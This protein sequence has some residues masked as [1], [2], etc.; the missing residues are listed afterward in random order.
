MERFSTDDAGRA[1]ERKRRRD[2]NNKHGPVGMNK[3]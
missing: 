3:F 1:E 2:E